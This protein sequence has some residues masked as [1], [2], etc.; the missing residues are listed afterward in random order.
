MDIK[1]NLLTQHYLSYVEGRRLLVP[2]LGATV[3]ITIEYSVFNALIDT[4]PTR[5]CVNKVYYQ[6]L[7]F[8]QLHKVFC[9][10]VMSSLG[11]N[12]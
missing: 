12:L 7:M 6:S 8:H 9:T 2:L 3:S 1:C 5:S 4:G 11:H 10:A